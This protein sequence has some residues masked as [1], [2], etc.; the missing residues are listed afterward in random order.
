MNAETNRLSLERGDVMV[1]PVEARAE[2]RFSSMARHMGR[3]VNHVLGQQYHRFCPSDAWTPAVN[4]SEGRD[5]YGVVVDL[6]GVQTET[7]ELQ[8][9]PGVMMI[10][11][12]REVPESPAGPGPGRV[13]LME[14]DHGRFCRRID[15]PDDVDVDAAVNLSASYNNGLLY[16]QLPRKP[17]T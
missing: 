11:G 14:I 13:H 7:I 5:G 8:I 10:V 17:R 12:R 1:L 3:W 15:L 16:I 2:D 4:F 6:A 9:E